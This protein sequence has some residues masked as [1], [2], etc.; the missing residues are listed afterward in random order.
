MSGDTRIAVAAVGF[1][2]GGTLY[3]HRDAPMRWLEQGQTAIKRVVDA[4][5]I[6][7]SK[8]RVTLDH[9]GRAGDGSRLRKLIRRVAASEVG[10]HVFAAFFE[11]FRRSLEAYPDAIETLAALK[12]SGFAVG[13]LTNVPLGMPRRT[14]QQD[15]GRLGL[16][17]YIDGFVTSF[18]VG[19]RKP[20]RAPFERLATMLAV[21]LREIA[22]VGNLPTDV[23]GAL[24][25]GCVPIFL[26]RAGKGIDYGQAATVHHLTEILP[27]LTPIS[28][29]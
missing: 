11:F 12:K 7:R 13:A 28:G 20:R 14:I 5:G 24:A 3:H 17:S 9:E 26:D 10:T 4:C 25:A 23:S 21:D 6:D 29:R 19:L 15:L 22:Y 18:E 27:L 2:L 8:A 16:A 1:D